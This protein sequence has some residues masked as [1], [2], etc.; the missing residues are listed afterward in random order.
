MALGTKPKL[1]VAARGQRP[2]SQFRGGAAIAA[3]SSCR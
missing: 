3:E 1:S 2:P